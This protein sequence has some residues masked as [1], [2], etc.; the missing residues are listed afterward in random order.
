[1]MYRNVTALMPMKHFSQRV[2]EKNYRNI[3]GKP[4]FVW[5]LNSLLKSKRI[6]QIIINTDSP[7]IEKIVRSLDIK[8]ITLI[9]RP[10]HLLGDVDI[11]SLIEHD[12]NFAKND[13][14]LQTHSTNPLLRH[15]TIDS[16]INDFEKSENA[17]SL[18]GVTKL[19]KRLYNNKGE[20]LN[21][22]PLS[23]NLRTQDLE[24]LYIENSCIYLFSKESFKKN[25]HRICTPIIFY[26]I[27]EIE[28]IDIDEPSDLV[29]AEFY[30]K[31]KLIDI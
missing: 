22:N 11:N 30:L 1:M 5:V 20:A 31:N 8:S 14:I 7:I 24:P 9:D 16:A 27:N 18:V 6:D 19:Q 17:K 3:A 25:N 13:L 21:H 12:I 26:D 2:K 15:E 10:K 28:S 4:L 29:F 23:K